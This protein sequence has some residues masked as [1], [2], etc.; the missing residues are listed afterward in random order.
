[1][2]SG[3]VEPCLNQERMG[4]PNYM[5]IWAR[6]CHEFVIGAQ[7]LLGATEGTQRETPAGQGDLSRFVSVRGHARKFMQFVPSFILPLRET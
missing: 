7:L 2:V 6:R 5:L 4:G 1:M 3:D